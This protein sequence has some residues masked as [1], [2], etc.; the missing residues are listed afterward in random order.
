MTNYCMHYKYK[1]PLPEELE[2]VP[3]DFQYDHSKILASGTRC[4]DTY[5][6]Y[7]LQ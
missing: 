5:T 2:L 1:I 6:F 3:A 7:L 4:N